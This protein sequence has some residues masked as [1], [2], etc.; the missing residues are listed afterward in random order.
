VGAHSHELG[1]LPLALANGAGHHSEIVEEVDGLLHGARDEVAL[2]AGLW[3]G[4]RWS[5]AHVAVRASGS[6]WRG[7][8][9]IA[10]ARA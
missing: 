4:A 2:E 5:D 8:T 7:W 10:R 6:S 3:L 9:M 1:A